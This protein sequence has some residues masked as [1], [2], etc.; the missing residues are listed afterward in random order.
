M[1][2]QNGST[3]VHAGIFYWSNQE[4]AA[5]SHSLAH[6]EWQSGGVYV[7]NHSFSSSFSRLLAKSYYSLPFGRSKEKVE[8]IKKKSN[9]QQV[10]ELYYCNTMRSSCCQ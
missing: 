2:L 1:L 4:H 10:I 9:M 5:S 7:N 3:R 8:N 6:A